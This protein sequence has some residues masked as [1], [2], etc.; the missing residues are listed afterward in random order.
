[1]VDIVVLVPCLT[2]A[3]LLGLPLGQPP[4]TSAQEDRIV[5][6]S[7][8]CHDVAAGARPE[9]TVTLTNR[10]GAPLTITDLHGI[11]VTQ[12]FSVLMRTTAPP[13]MPP[14]AVPD[15]ETRTPRAPWDDLGQGPGFL[16]AALVVT[17]AGALVPGCSDRLADA[18]ELRLGPPPIS[19][20][21]A[22][23]EAVTIAVET[24]GRLESWRAYPALYQLLH[25]DARAVT[26]FAAVACWYAAQFGLPGEP[27][28]T[29]VFRTAVDE[30]TFGPWIWGVTGRTYPDAAA[31]A[32][33]QTVGTIAA[34]E[35]VSAA[36]HLVAADG[37]WRW[38]F[39]VS[40]EAL[41]ALPAGCDL[42]PAG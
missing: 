37:Q 1:M 15:G 2:L 27:Q 33:R 28:Q 25:S 40:P 8:R 24:L 7:A 32:Y 16:G 34:T 39:G 17:S 4:V 13:D 12:A 42:D 14:L 36:M 35:E 10:T 18:D 21:A 22:R 31:V 30:I 29:L 9:I 38:F 19:D 23:R 6:A 41:A 11:T 5:T 26:P 3:T 20:E